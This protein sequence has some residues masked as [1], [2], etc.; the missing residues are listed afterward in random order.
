M[1]YLVKRVSLRSR[2]YSGEI[3]KKSDKAAPP[4]ILTWANVLLEQRVE[5]GSTGFLLSDLAYIALKE[6]LT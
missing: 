2:L 1:C 3:G 5:T 6:F 4:T